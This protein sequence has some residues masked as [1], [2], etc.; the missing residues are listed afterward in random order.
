M[1]PVRVAMLFA[2]PL[3]IACGGGNGRSEPDAITLDIP[4]DVPPVPSIDTVVSTTAAKAGQ[5]VEV[6]CAGY[7]FNTATVEL[8]VRLADTGTVT[9]PPGDATPGQ[10]AT[11]PPP[12]DLPPDLT[13]PPGVQRDG[14]VLRFAYTDV[15]SVACW[16]PDAQML[17]PS[18][19]RVV[20]RPGSAQDVDTAVSPDHLKAG[21][22]ATVTCTGVD[23]YGNSLESQMVPV[24]DPP[25]GVKVTGMAVQFEKV[26]EYRVACAVKDTV[27]QDPTPVTVTVVNN[28][29]RRIITVVTPL[30]F[31][32]GESASLSCKV[33]D[34][35]DNPVTDLPVS[36]QVPAGL[37]LAGKSLTT[38]L[39]GLYTV[40]C[41]PETAEWSHFT[42]VP[43]SVTVIPGPPVT[44]TLDPVPDKPFYGRN[45]LLTVNSEARDAFGNLVPDAAIQAPVQVSPLKGIVAVAAD[46]TRKFTLKDEGV[47][48]MTFRLVDFP[49]VQAEL[50]V[51]VEGSGPLLT[52]VYP[53]RGETVTGNKPAITLEGTVNDDQTGITKFQVNGKDVSLKQ[54]QPDGEFTYVFSPLKQG[55]NVVTVSME[56]GAGLAASETRGFYY[57]PK[58]YPPPDK[59]PLGANVPRGAQAFLSQQFIDDTDH[60]LPPDDLATILEMV[61]AGLDLKALIPNPLAEAGP[62][63]VLLTQV[64]Y[65]KP[66]FDLILQEGG[67]NLR[68][69]IPDVFV[70]IK[71]EGRCDF[72]IDWCPDVSGNVQFTK[73]MAIAD[74]LIGMDAQG[75]LTATMQNIQVQLGGMDVNIDGL[76][77]DLLDPIIDL[78]V[79]AFKDTLKQTLVDQVSGIVND[80]LGNLLSQLV[81]DQAFEI[82]A[83]PGGTAKS[84]R[85]R[86]KPSELAVHPEGIDVALDG[87]LSA[88]KGVTHSPLGSIG[89]AG[90]LQVG[91]DNTKPDPYLLPTDEE[92]VIGAFDDLLNQALFAVWYGGSLNLKL[93]GADLGGADLTQYGVD[94]LNGV[95]LDFY[96]PPMLSDCNLKKDP[97]K[98]PPPANTVPIEAQ[99]GDLY[100]FADLVLFGNPLQLG[101]FAQATADAVLTL[102]TNAT[103]G[104]KEVAIA[105]ESLPLLN[106]DIVS[107]NEDFPLTKEDLMGMLQGQL[108]DTLLKGVLG[109]QLFSFAIPSIDLSGLSPMLPPG[110]EITV[111]LTAL[112]REK[113]HSVVK[114][115][116]RAP[117][118]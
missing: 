67:L 76:L 56:N 10:D 19:A 70:G 64:T 40:K 15:Y 68:M 31:A 5:P 60:S 50:E 114:G 34:Y 84:I 25:A 22:W 95:N 59:A 106:L 118:N 1:K 96:L 79:N 105:L 112:L 113:G 20:V 53:G 26:G 16:A 41:V 55:L 32:A 78:L 71:A 43:A 103:T 37:T 61:V 65:G 27:I 51:R 3:A 102:S 24:V 30:T 57:S 66:R 109:T 12:A 82:P 87:T 80:T 90:C 111:D 58:F 49:E 8:V 108:L 54:I 101:L 104:Q 75:T 81:I 13:L 18:P 29:P 47:Y 7:G 94:A 9:P 74:V 91:Y 77:G 88:A 42:L 73:L 45:E 52:L 14:M 36:V 28:L 6:T 11:E 99:I 93:T 4:E 2:L 100:V 97:T 89:R 92:V 38:T 17:D 116:L 72:I 86:V 110:L 117:T 63:K 21:E 44:L 98:P 83:L 39:A 62:Y 85:A 107:I 35:Y 48:V 33:V 115:L 69:T 46:P 23:A